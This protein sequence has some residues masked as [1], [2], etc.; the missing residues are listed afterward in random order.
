VNRFGAALRFITFF[1]WLFLCQGIRLSFMPLR[2]RDEARDRRWKRW[3]L[4]RWARGACRIAGIRVVAKGPRPESPGLLFANHL[5]YLDILVLAQQT[6]YIFVAMSEIAKWPMLGPICSSLYVIFMDRKDKTKAG[7]VIPTIAHAIQMGDGVVIFPEGKITRGIDVAPFH[8][9][10]VEPARAIG[11]TVTCAT[12]HYETAP[13]SPPASR[14]LLW[15]RPEPPHPHFLRL[16][17]YPGSTVTVSYTQVDTQGL[18]RK[19]LAV[20][21]HDAVKSHFLPHP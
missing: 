6:G 20:R 4:Q 7:E 2:R 21:M 17:R 12:L 13:G 15:W 10:V 19:Q 1:G 8:S 3:W 18:D 9:P 11:G 16:L 5:S 14:I